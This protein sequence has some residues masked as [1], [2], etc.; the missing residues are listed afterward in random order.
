MSEL[1]EI[2]G[3]ELIHC[4][5]DLSAADQHNSQR[6]VILFLMDCFSLQ[7]QGLGID[8]GFFLLMRLGLNSML[9]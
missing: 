9:A 4:P 6:E 5:E 8:S 3:K 2:S 1:S 7:I